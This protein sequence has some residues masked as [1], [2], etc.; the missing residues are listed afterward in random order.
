MSQLQIG[1]P[2]PI[3]IVSLL[4]THV[5]KTVYD[6]E[7]RI[8]EVLNKQGKHIRGEWYDLDSETLDIL[9]AFFNSV[10][11]SESETK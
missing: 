7:I 3:K 6:L 9:L 11:N 5:M 1:N 10:G 8:H 4:K 2:Y